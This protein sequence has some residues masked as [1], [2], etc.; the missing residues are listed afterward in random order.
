MRHSLLQTA[1][2]DFISKLIFLLFIS[3]FISGMTFFKIFHSFQFIK[4]TLQNVNFMKI[5]SFQSRFTYKF[6]FY[7]KNVIG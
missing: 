4:K 7:W 5:L 3:F 6:L 2:Q 1:R